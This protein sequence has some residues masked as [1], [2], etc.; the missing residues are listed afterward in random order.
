MRKRFAIM[1][2][3]LASIVL[4]LCI[5]FT[6]LQLTIN[7]RTFLEYEYGRLSLAREMGMSN[8]DLIASCQR[9]I[10]YMEGRVD[11]IDIT[12]T[13]DGEQTLMFDQQ[14]EVSHMRD[15][16]TIY[17]ACRTMRDFGVL[18][19]LV[20]YLLGALLHMRTA[21]HTLASGYCCGAFVVALFAA[22]LG[23]WAALDFSNFWTFFHQMLFWNDDW[24]FDAA[25]SRMINMLPERFF[26]DVIVRMA[27]LFGA[28][29][30]ALAAASAA[31]LYNIRKKR[32][33]ARARALARRRAARRQAQKEAGAAQPDAPAAPAA[34]AP[35][36]SARQAAEPAARQDA[37]AGREARP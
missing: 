5:L 1:L 19:A 29:L 14:Q 26:A 13:V 3:T 9:L 6:A 27:A 17:Q 25:A 4:I 28:A 15:V 32:R 2:S 36:E 33:A 16:R 12:V 22:F 21:L 34:D 10:D 35:G 20:L 7:N 24:L 8:N 11:S 30:L 23:T 37:P 18:L 31:A